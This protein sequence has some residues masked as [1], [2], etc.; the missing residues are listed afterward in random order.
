[1]NYTHAIRNTI[2][3]IGIIILL[4]YSY[5]KAHHYYYYFERFSPI[6]IRKKTLAINDNR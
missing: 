2:G 5:T 3:I 4:C 6:K 1:M